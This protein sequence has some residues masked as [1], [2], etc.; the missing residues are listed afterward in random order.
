MLSTEPITYT[1]SRLSA[2][3]VTICATDGRLSVHRLLVP[4]PDAF[5]EQLRAQTTEI[6]AAVAGKTYSKETGVWL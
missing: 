6:L 1:L 2:V 3:G 5:R 4:L